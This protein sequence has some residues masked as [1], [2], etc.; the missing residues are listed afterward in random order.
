VVVQ[1]LNFY[2]SVQLIATGAPVISIGVTPGNN[3]PRSLGD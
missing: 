2:G 3:D 1:V